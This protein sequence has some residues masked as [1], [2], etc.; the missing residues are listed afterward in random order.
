[1]KKTTEFDK[2][3]YGLILAAG[4][5]RRMKYPKPF[6]FYNQ[7][8]FVE[9]VVNNLIRAEIINNIIVITPDHKIFYEQLKLPKTSYVGNSHPERG[10]IESIQLGLKI[11]P[12]NIH[13]MFLTLVDHP[14]VL[15]S[16]YKLLRKHAS[17]HPGKI[18]VPLFNDQ[19][20][21]P[22]FIPSCHFNSIVSLSKQ[23]RLD[24]YIKNKSSLFVEFINCNDPGILCDIDSFFDYKNA[25]IQFQERN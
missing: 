1:M 9:H 19:K 25:L 20:G 4:K 10:M 16:T 6:L 8:T 5:S 22:I 18:I 13:G 7:K 12:P 3:I 24:S 2:L 23:E 14:F 17:I 11:I 21:H 15:P